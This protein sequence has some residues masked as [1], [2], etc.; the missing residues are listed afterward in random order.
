MQIKVKQ[1]MASCACAATLAFPLLPGL[2]HAQTSTTP[3]AQAAPG[4][5]PAA[6]PVIT[7]VKPLDGA[8]AEVKKV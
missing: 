7:D 4:A 3:A 2:T 8:G 1:L 6:L 5:T